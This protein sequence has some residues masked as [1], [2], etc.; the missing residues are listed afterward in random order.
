VTTVPVPPERA[1]WQ[2]FLA[3]VPDAMV[4][5]DREGRIVLVNALAARMFGYRSDDLH[6]KRF[7]VLVPSCH[8]GALARHRGESGAAIVTPTETPLDVSG[9]RRD[10][11]EVPVEITLSRA[12]VEGE[13]ALV[14][15]IRDL[16]WRQTRSE[17]DVRVVR[18][19]AARREAE[20]AAQRARLLADACHHLSASVDDDTLAEVAGVVV[21]GFADWCVIYLAL[22]DGTVRR[23]APRYADPDKQ[24]AAAAMARAASRLT[25]MPQPNAIVDVIRSG[26]SLLLPRVTRD[27]FERALPDDEYRALVIE[28]LHPRSII[29][30]PLVARGATVGAITCISGE[31]GREYDPSDLAFAEDLAGRIALAVDN[32]RLYRKAERAKLEAEAASRAKAE[33]LAMIADELRNPLDAIHGAVEILDRVGQEP[34]RTSQS[35]DV[36]KRQAHHLA[37]IVDDLLDVARLTTGKIA[38]AL[39]P[40]DLGAVTARCAGAVLGEGQDAQ[41]VVDLHVE[42]TWV[43]GDVTRLEQIAVNLLTNARKFTSPGDRISIRVGAESDDAVLRV[44]DTGIGIPREFLPHVFD[45][46][47]QGE[48]RVDRPAGGLGIG[49][50]LVARLV[51][52][53]GGRVEAHSEGPGTG[54]TFVVRLPRIEPPVERRSEPIATERQERRTLLIVEDNAEVREALRI[55]LEVAGHDV[56]DVGSGEAAVDLAL[57]LRPD[58][59]LIDLGLPG[60]DGYEVA[61]RLRA[62]GLTTQLI[63]VSGYGQP[64]ARRRA[65]AA[66]FDV[67]LVKP[68]DGV[69][70][71]RVVAQS[72]SQPPIG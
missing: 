24:A 25:W 56:H 16:T 67:H 28:R 50:T 22:A 49:L 42:A 71:L 31:D 20:R 45:L 2:A 54:S 51:E 43:H 48:R 46:F 39:A 34:G 15:A 12:D 52:Q 29:V 64:E 58:V 60:V 41:R 10:G 1:A 13:P 62:A 35:R 44:E 37:R 23:I 36:I 38:L 68:V 19:Q 61:R 55:M 30:A 47:A 40:V 65:K 27:W 66:G 53:H 6:G 59:A 69:R 18:E 26:T 5:V 17:D 70:L 72:T 14:V 7:D 9:R 4:V 3:V 8:A 57:R 21:R 63:A 32:A 11:T 33:F